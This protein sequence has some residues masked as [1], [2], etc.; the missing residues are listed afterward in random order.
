MKNRNNVP[1]NLVIIF[2]SCSNLELL[3]GKYDLDKLDKILTDINNLDLNLQIMLFLSIFNFTN[4][5]ILI[6]ECEL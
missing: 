5:L 4:I 6:W 3:N 1:L 2:V